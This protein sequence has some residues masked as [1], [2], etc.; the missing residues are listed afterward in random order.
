MPRPARQSRNGV[1]LV[2]GQD[3]EHAIMHICDKLPPFS[4]SWGRGQRG[5]R[6]G[7]SSISITSKNGA[8]ALL[9]GIPGEVRRRNLQALGVVIDANSDMEARWKQIVDRFASVNI[10]LPASPNPDG[11]IVERGE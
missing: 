11:T 10:R 1:L 2:E 5:I 9:A 8:D 3:D 7:E 6:I 4:V